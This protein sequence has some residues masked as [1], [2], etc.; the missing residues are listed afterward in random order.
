MAS[1]DEILDDKPKEKVEKAEKPET[2]LKIPVL[3]ET[4]PEKPEV[5]TVKSSRKAAREKEYEA[6]G[7]NP[8]GTFKAK[9]EEP[10]KAEI[11]AESEKPKVEQAK[12]KPAAPQQE[13][14]EKEKAFLKAAHEERAKRQAAETRIAAL[15]A[16]AKSAEPVKTF[17]DDPDAALAKQRQEMQQALITTRIQTAEMIARGRHADFDEKIEIFRQIA[18]ANPLIVQQM[19]ASIDPA[20][21]AYKLAANHKAVMD[22]GGVD[23]LVEKA[24]AEERVK[25]AA[26][27]KTKAE[28]AAAL[29]AKERAALP[30]TLSDTKGTSGTRVAWAGP[31]SLEEILKK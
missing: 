17:Y 4:V 25:V 23:Q 27:L 29:A 2:E 8:D 7:R 3:G 11:K 5:E 16:A 15:E 19:M 6:Q 10:A 1:L 13:F 30:G 21:Y 31:T 14:T 18:E 24:R 28:E 12:E 20:E 9:E 26:E 22:A